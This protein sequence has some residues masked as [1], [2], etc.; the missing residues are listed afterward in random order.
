M[1]EYM[2]E[3]NDDPDTILGKIQRRMISLSISP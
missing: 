2:L 1:E 3:T